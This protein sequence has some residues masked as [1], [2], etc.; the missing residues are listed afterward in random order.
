MT[1][2]ERFNMLTIWVQDVNPNLYLEKGDARCGCVYAVVNKGTGKKLTNFLKLPV[3]EQYLLG[4]FYSKEFYKY[5]E[6]K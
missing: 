3:L 5:A 6:E 1:N 2:K 4:V